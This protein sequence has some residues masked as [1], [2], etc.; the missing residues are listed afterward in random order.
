MERYDISD[1]GPDDLYVVD[2]DP[3]FDK[4]VKVVDDIK[5]RLRESPQENF[6]IV[7][8]LAG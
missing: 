6:L 7:Y 1:T 4:M 3:D 5:Q 2:N 8:I